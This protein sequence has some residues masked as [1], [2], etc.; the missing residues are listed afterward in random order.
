MTN[1]PDKSTFGRLAVPIGLS[2]P[3]GFFLPLLLHLT[4]GHLY[5]PV[6]EQWGHWEEAWFVVKLISLFGFSSIGVL[7]LFAIVAMV[8]RN[9]AWFWLFATPAIGALAFM[10]FISAEDFRILT[11]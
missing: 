2:L 7:L 5:L 9:K 1:E 11:R 4:I 6:P 8:R 3:T 10:L